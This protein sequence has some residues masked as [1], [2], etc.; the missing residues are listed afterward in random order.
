MLSKRNLK[1]DDLF[2]LTSVTNPQLSPDGKEAVFIQTHIDEEENKYVANLFHVDLETNEVTQWTHG[3][4]RV[5]SPSWSSDG[6][7]IAFLSNREEKNQVFILPARGGE[8]KKLTAFEKGVTSF[9]WSPCGKKVWVNA[10][11]EEGKTFT[12]K[13][14]KDEKKKPEPY[15]VTKMKYHMDGIGLLPQDAYRQI[16]V[17]DIESGEVTQ[18]TEGNHQYALQAISHDGKKLVF[19]VNRK[20]NQ[21]FEFRQPLYIVDVESKEE[22]VLVDENG[23]FGGAT[24]SH[25]DRYIA[26]VGADNTFKNATQAKLYV[27]DT[28]DGS[29]VCLTESIDAPVGDYVAADHQQGAACTRGSLDE[30]RSAIFPIDNNGRCTT[31]F[32]FT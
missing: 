29:T 2:E 10:V 12:D 30:R 16:G 8:A 27:Y 22:T 25:N 28:E 13:E 23:Y 11:V 32:R 3:K 24:F 20:E 31:L 9:L 19:G 4:D 1:V 26:Y 5:S 15:R 14:E 21:D 17:V 7:Q 6:K 18:F